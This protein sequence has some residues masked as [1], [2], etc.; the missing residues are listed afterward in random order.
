M[1]EWMANVESFANVLPPYQSRNVSE[2]TERP[3]TSAVQTSPFS[4][5][6]PAVSVP[7][8]MISPAASGSLGNLLRTAVPSSPRHK[9]GLRREFLPDPSSTNSPFFIIRTLQRGKL[10]AS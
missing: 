7:V 5:K 2:G 1:L 6:C 8:L 4:I 3:V 10:S 9:A